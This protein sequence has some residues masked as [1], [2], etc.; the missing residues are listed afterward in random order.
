MQVMIDIGTNIIVVIATIVGLLAGI[1]C[2]LVV[3]DKWL[4]FKSGG[5]E[6]DGL[7]SMLAS[8]IVKSDKR[9]D[10]RDQTQQP[11]ENFDEPSD[12]SQK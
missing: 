2:F 10:L 5:R 9:Q 3:V 8:S 12:S 4:K 1:Y 7:T 6:Q 11:G